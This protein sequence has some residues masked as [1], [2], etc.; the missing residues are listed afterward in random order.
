M[1]S[2]AYREMNR[3][4]HLVNPDFGV[5]GHRYAGIVQEMTQN[6]GTKDILDYGCGKRTLEMA[7]GFKISNYDPCIDGLDETPDPHDIVVC[8]D[9][10]E[11]IEPE[12]LDSVL[13]DLRRVTRIAALLTIDTREASKSL[14]DGRNAHLI[15]QKAPWWLPRIWAAGFHV[16]GLADTGNRIKL[17]V[18]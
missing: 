14:P 5:N 3:H 1:I 9:V 11:H 10:L 13:A 12:E 2:P 15:I 18:K 7:L 8:S 17:T 16:R 6:L 4:L